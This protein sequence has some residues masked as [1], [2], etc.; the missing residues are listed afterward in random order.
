MTTQEILQI[1]S[2]FTREDWQ[3]FDN[4]RNIAF[5]PTQAEIDLQVQEQEQARINTINS[6]LT[7][8][9]IVRPQV[10]T[11]EF[12][13]WLLASM[14]A[15]QFIWEDFNGWID[16]QIKLFWNLETAFDDLVIRF[17]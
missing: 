7:N 12:V 4:I 9:W 15:E 3:N 11:K 2:T 8:L 5:Q 16:N 13:L 1:F 17:L 14:K 10:I 6:K